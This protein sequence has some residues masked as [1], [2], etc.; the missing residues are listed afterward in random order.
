[1]SRGIG[2]YANLILQDDNTVIYEYGGYNL[3]EEKYRNEAHIYDGTITIQRSCFLEPEIHEKIKKMPNGKKKPVDKRVTVEVDYPRYI[4][5]GLIVIENCSN[6]WKTTNDEKYIDIMAL[7]IL[8]YLFL[9][10]QEQGKMP[11]YISYNV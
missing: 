4:E 1:M 5:D 2:A 3:N 11:E 9:R 7:H 8:Y 6:C 10:Y